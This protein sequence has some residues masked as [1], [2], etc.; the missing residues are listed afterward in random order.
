M[1]DERTKAADQLNRESINTLKN[2][3]VTTGEFVIVVGAGVSIPLI[4]SGHGLRETMAKKCEIDNNTTEHYWKFFQK[5]Q[6]SKAGYIPSYY[7]SDVL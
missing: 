7:Y 3:G 1:V 5:S 2:M 6:E 4:P